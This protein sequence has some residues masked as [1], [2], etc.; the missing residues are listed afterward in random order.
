MIFVIKL[1]KEFQKSQ[2]NIECQRSF[3]LGLFIVFSF[4]EEGTFG[5]K[6]FWPL[7]LYE[8]F[9]EM[10]RPLLESKLGIWKLCSLN[11]WMLWNYFLFSYVSYA[12]RSLCFMLDY[13]NG[14]H[15]TYCVCNEC[16]ILFWFLRDVNS[17]YVLCCIYLSN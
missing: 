1:L 5:P 14:A 4:W 16:S 2:R 8:L 6:E 7:I 10:N 15:A 9:L 12:V 3:I 17:N 11:G 13:S